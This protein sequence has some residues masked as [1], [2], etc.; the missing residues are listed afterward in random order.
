MLTDRRPAALLLVVLALTACSDQ[1]GSDSDGGPSAERVAAVAAARQQL[2]PPAAE[3]ASAVTTI[4]SSLLEVYAD[5]DDPNERLAAIDGIR[6]ELL[7]RLRE[8]IDGARDVDLTADPSQT[9]A[10]TAAWDVLISN[11]AGVP[12]AVQDDLDHLERL[13]EAEVALLELAE[14]WQES[15]SRNEQIARLEAT[16]AAAA[17]LETSL[18]QLQQRTECS[19]AIAHRLAAARHVSAA[20]T[21]LRDLVASQRGNE[22]DQRRAELAQDPLG[23]GA[24]L[25]D[26]DGDDVSCWEDE[27]PTSVAV[28]AVLSAVDRLEAALNPPDVTDG[29]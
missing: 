7:P 12:G 19:R 28:G 29:S 21:E 6:A 20:S 4:G 9:E 3:L 5:G 22:F 1:A 27:L 26:L 10:I 16:A 17:D 24:S 25:A 18:T 15:G 11:A 13:L 23:L 14:T 8:E 2:G